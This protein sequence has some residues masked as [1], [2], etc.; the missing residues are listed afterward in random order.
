MDKWRTKLIWTATGIPTPDSAL[1]TRADDLAGVVE[2]VGLP[3]IVKP[4]REG[5]TIGLSKVNSA[6]E[7]R[8]AWELAA[9][10]DSLVLAEAFIAGQE[11][12]AAVLGDAALPLVR[13]VAPQGNYD[14]HNKYFSN[15]TKY[16]CPA[17]IDPAKETEIRELT[18]RAFRV[19]GCEGWGR[20]DLIL[21]DDGSISFLEMNTSPGMTGHSLVPMAAK[22]AGLGFADLALRILELSLD[23]P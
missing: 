22:R 16:Y 5:S 1:L 18:L 14:Y 13:I 9:R 7:L 6:A 17:G 12:T 19:L 4:V 20:A 23:K 8:P 21:R 3:L 10:Y 2:R 15:D 11:L